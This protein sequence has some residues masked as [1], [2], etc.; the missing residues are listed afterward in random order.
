MLHQ[1]V[2]SSSSSGLDK[3][4]IFLFIISKFHH[5]NK[6]LEIATLTLDK[7]LH[8]TNH[9]QHE[10]AISVDLADNYIFKLLL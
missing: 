7:F 2:E 4:C 1:H 10:K 3:S 9:N 5:H 8:D 6:K